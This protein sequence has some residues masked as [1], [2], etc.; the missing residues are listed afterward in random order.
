L[1]TAQTQAGWQLPQIFRRFLEL[2]PEEV[3]NFSGWFS[4]RFPA[5]AKPGGR[6]QG[7]LALANNVWASPSC[8]LASL[9]R[10]KSKFSGITH[11]DLVESFAESLTEGIANQ[12]TS[13]FHAETY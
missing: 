1:Q 13:R 4:S 7:S 9:K 3:E 10:R 11:Q 6:T 8:R 2:L 12:K 5:V